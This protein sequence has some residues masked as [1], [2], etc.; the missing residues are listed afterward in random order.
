MD[1]T[2]SH[3]DLSKSFRKSSE[4]SRK[5]SSTGGSPRKVATSSTASAGND[6]SRHWMTIMGGTA[7]SSPDSSK[8]SHLPVTPIPNGRASS[9][10][11]LP[12]QLIPISESEIFDDNQPLG[13]RKPMKPFQCKKCPRKFERKGHLKVSGNFWIIFYCNLDKIINLI[14]PY[15]LKPCE[16]FKSLMLV[17]YMNCSSHTFVSSEVAIDL[18]VI[19]LV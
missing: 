13:V 12:N 14:E 1:D 19:S 2:K 5:T 10:L 3:S 4:Q 7:S 15:L 16:F 9:I 6:R 17:Q 8:S 11:P 18:S